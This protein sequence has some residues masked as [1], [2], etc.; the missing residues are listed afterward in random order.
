MDGLPLSHHWNQKEGSNFTN[1]SLISIT[2]LNGASVILKEDVTVDKI[3]K[4]KNVALSLAGVSHDLVSF[5]SWRI[6]T[7]RVQSFS[8]SRRPHCQGFGVCAVRVALD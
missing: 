5:E 3:F 6:R 7:F 1:L 4:M 2:L 8:G